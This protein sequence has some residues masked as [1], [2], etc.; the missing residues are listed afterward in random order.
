MSP[1]QPAHPEDALI[2]AAGKGVRMGGL[3]RA[4]P[5][6][7]LPIA[8]MPILEVIGRALAAS[9]IRRVHVVVGYLEEVIR[10]YFRGRPLAA[11]DGS[12]VEM[13]FIRQAEA[14]GT[15]SAVLLGKPFLSGGPFLMAF[16]DIIVP[17][18][19]YGRMLERYARGG[20]DAVLSTRRVPDPCFGAAVYVENDRVV[21]IIEKPKPGTST[22]H[23]D[24]AGLFVF[25]PEVF[26]LLDQ[27][28]LSPRGEYELTDAIAMMLER[29]MVI[30]PCEMEGFWVNLVGPETLL[31]A[32]TE[33][34][35]WKRNAGEPM[36]VSDTCRVGD[37]R[38]G[39]SVSISPDVT[40]GDGCDIDDAILTA[41]TRVGD[42]AQLRYVITQP[43]AE[44]PG[45]ARIEGASDKVAVIG[46]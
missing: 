21:K 18:V 6:P 24:N 28:E 40:I 33:V 16:G 22:T 41:G 43:G 32:N 13:N 17:G 38:I 26:D 15:G 5:K 37:S 42:G 25:Q 7:M 20:C 12:R 8:N 46:G 44:V 1:E 29:D 45:S 36:P 27:V 35:T 34:M 10:D 11:P 2:L 19:N 39:P 4:C 31:K 30:A 23:F 14:T 3:C 9:G